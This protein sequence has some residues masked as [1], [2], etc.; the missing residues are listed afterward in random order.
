MGISYLERG[1]RAPRKQTVNRLEQALG[2]P[3]GTYRRLSLAADA[4]AELAAIMAAAPAVSVGVDRSGRDP[5]AGLL[6]AHAAAHARAWRAVIAR[7]P[8]ASAPDSEL[9][10]QFV[11]ERCMET[12]GL[13][14]ESWRVAAASDPAVAAEL[15]ENLEALEL[16]RR[17]A[18]ARLA[19]R[20]LS[21]RLDA[22]C[23]ASPLPDAVVAQMLG[24][25]AE[26]LWQWRNQGVIPAEVVPRVQEFVSRGR[27]SQPDAEQPT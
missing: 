1:Q 22:A 26:E 19:K 4:D 13:T 27:R 6:G 14:A 11:L 2:L 20:S 23:A 17:E 24:G 21:A 16:D 10:S 7:M 3:P 15:L 18:S 12:V 5:V 25:T 9:Y 8:S